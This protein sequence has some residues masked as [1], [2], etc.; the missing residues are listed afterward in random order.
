M[1]KVVLYKTISSGIYQTATLQAFNKMW[2]KD[3][4]IF[5]TPLYVEKC[6]V[7]D[8]IEDLISGKV[9]QNY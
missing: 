5:F 1:S 3:V 8:I 6:E 9:S 7:N 2:N 4:S